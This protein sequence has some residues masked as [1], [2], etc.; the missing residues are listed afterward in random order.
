MAEFTWRGDTY[1]Y[2]TNPLLVEIMYVERKL[3]MEGE[4]FTQT[5][6]TIVTWFI[7]IKR[8]RP[9]TTWEEVVNST[10]DEF[11]NL[12]PVLSTEQEPTAEEDLPLDP[13]AAGTLT[14]PP[15]GS[16]Q[17]VAS[18]SLTRETPTS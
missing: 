1:E 9:T 16:G 15:S 18:A 17:H 7:S 8:R 6:N 4:E 10:Q 2:V 11:T 3:G 13:T 12:V 14:D 5:E